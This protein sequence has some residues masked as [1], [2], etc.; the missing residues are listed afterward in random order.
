MPL[1]LKQNQ[2][3]TPSQGRAQLL[4]PQVSS[5]LKLNLL[6]HGASANRW[7]QRG[8]NPK[9]EEGVVSKGEQQASI[10]KVGHQSPVRTVSPFP[11][12]RLHLGKQAPQ[13][14]KAFC[15]QRAEGWLKTLVMGKL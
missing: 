13:H 8:G 11:A 14:A 15:F 12:T 4:F 10:S 3:H 2:K 9:A 6:R 1:I 7:E 5:P